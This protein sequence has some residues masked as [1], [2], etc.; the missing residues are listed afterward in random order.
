MEY[1]IITLKTIAAYFILLVVGTNLI[2]VVIRG[3]IVTNTLNTDEG[4][5]EVYGKAGHV[6][7]IIFVFLLIGYL[8]A[9]TI[10]SI[11]GF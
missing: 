4:A 2:G 8:Y 3:F 11:F 9:Y 1:L 6:M 10:S 7:T 5:R